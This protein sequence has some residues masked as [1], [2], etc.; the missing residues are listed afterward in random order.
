[1][2]IIYKKIK[3][4]FGHS[5]VSVFYTKNNKLETIFS[6]LDEI[7]NV[8]DLTKLPLSIHHMY[9]NLRLFVLFTKSLRHWSSTFLYYRP[10]Q[11]IDR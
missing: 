11:R 10:L 1:M 7:R 3:Y 8:W 5:E 9:L 2:L 6:N 4:L